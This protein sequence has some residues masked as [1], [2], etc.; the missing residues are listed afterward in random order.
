MP[1]KAG[2]SFPFQIHFRSNHSLCEDESCLAK[3][4]VVFQSETELKVRICWAVQ[5]IK[6]STKDMH[7]CRFE[8]LLLCYFIVFSWTEMFNF[9]LLD[10]IFDGFIFLFKFSEAQYSRAWRSYVAF[11]TQCCLAGKFQFCP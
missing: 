2:V 3:K 8:L 4:F 9:P 5:I 10:F 11:P 7:T 6:G 1:I